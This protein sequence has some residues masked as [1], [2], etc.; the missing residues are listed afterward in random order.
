MLICDIV[1]SLTSVA[2]FQSSPVGTIHFLPKHHI[3]GDYVSKYLQI[4]FASDFGP[5]LIHPNG[6]QLMYVTGLE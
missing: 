5:P 3:I 1:L 4:G 6:Y 2:R